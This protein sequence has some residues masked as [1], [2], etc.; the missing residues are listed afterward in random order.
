MKKLL[1]ILSF[2]YSIS[3]IG[4]QQISSRL[5]YGLFTGLSL[6][7]YYSIQT[8]NKYFIN[9][10]E[11]YIPLENN[12]IGQNVSKPYDYYNYSNDFLPKTKFGGNIGISIMYQLNG[13]YSFITGLT[14]EQKGIDHIESTT[15]PETVNSFTGIIAVIENDKLSNHI[16][17]DYVIVPLR[18]R[19]EYVSGYF[20]EVGGYLGF[21]QSSVRSLKIEH[22][23]SLYDQPSI[24]INNNR[25]EDVGK[26]I[27][28]S[29]IDFG[30]TLSNGLK[31]RINDYISF[32]CSS[33]LN[34]GL[35][36]LDGKYTNE[37]VEFQ[38]DKFGYTHFLKKNNYYG[39]NSYSKNI[40]L[41][42]NIGLEY[43]FQG[44][45]NMQP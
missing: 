23:R 9:T 36:K 44:I 38:N 30:L 29:K 45:D 22:Q 21:L 43:N 16:T 34:I 35:K 39:Y 2:V 1:F 31:L 41:L 11:H 13:S 12:V 19:R 33:I 10:G 14:Y 25:I 5:S 37:Y 6:S 18:I 7:N 15:K 40:N 24:I 28:T 32:V 8:P 4:Q 26:A 17:S 42:I 20:W 27:N 3:I